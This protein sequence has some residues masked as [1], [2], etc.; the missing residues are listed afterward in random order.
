M[1]CPSLPG[2]TPGRPKTIFNAAT[3][4]TPNARQLTQ[5]PSSDTESESL[6][7]DPN[8]GQPKP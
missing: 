1:L 6:G 8:A 2:P 3:L 4:K 5:K 7:P